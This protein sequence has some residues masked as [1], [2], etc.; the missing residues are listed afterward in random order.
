[1]VDTNKP[2]EDVR[3]VETPEG[4]ALYAVVRVRGT[5]NVR[6][7]IKHTLRL[8]HLTRANHCALV[9]KSVSNNGM[10]RKVKD[11]VT[12]GEISKDTLCELIKN[13]A[14]RCGN[15]KLTEDYIRAVTP[16][17]TVTELVDNLLAGTIK[18]GELKA[19][20]PV[21][22][23]PPPKKGYEGIK[24]AYTVGGALG[25]RGHAINDLLKRMMYNT[26]R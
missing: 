24:R 23:L 14:R 19:I 5:V 3:P 6:G 10:L 17:K 2:V 4:A 12:W 18:Y 21:F 13:Y 9:Y 8:L 26:A 25:Y 1:M 16:Y 7:D 22:R 11:Y 15:H 20:K